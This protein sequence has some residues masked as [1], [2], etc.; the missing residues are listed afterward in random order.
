MQW[1]PGAEAGDVIVCALRGT[2]A[3][4]PRDGISRVPP[5]TLAAAV[6]FFVMITTP[7]TA[8]SRR[9]AAAGDAGTAPLGMVEVF[10]LGVL[11]SI[12]NWRRAPG[13]AR[14]V[15]VVGPTYQPVR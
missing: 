10:M 13:G 12:V 2:L 15:G 6:T 5:L 8:A 14:T 7:I 4:A 3:P 11:V 9:R 1:L